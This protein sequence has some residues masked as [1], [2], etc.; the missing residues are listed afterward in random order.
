[1]CAI[2]GL[3]KKTIN[4]SDEKSM[5]KMGKLMNHRGPDGSGMYK[6]GELLML[7]KRLSIIDIQ[8]GKQ[9]IEDN[10]FVLVVNGEIYNDLEIRKE[11]KDYKFKTNSDSE[12]VLGLYKE[13]GIKGFKKL[14]G[15]YAFAIFDKKKK[16]LILGRDIFGIKPL[17]FFS[18]AD[19][20]IFSS[21]IQALIKSNYVSPDLNINKRNELLQIQ[22][23]SGR[24]TIFEKIKRVRPGEIILVKKNQIIESIIFKKIRKLKKKPVKNIH[25]KLIESVKLH[26]RSDVPYGSFFSGGIDSTLILYLMSIINSSPVKSYSI[27]FK[28]DL[29]EKDYL[30]KICYKLNSKLKFVEFTEKDFWSYLPKVA[31]IMDDPVIDYAI[32]PTYKL[33][34]IAKSDIKVVLT[35]EGGDEI[36]GGYGRYRSK[37]RRFLFKKEFL[38][39][40]AFSKFDYFKNILIGWDDSISFVKNKVYQTNFTDVQKAQYFDYEEWL[41]NDLLIKLDRC[42]MSQGIEGRTPLIDIEVFRNLFLIND[43]LK[44]SKGLGKYYIRQYFKKRL[45]YYFSFKKKSGFTVPINNWIPKYYKLLADILPKMKCLNNIFKKSKIESLCMNL[46][47]NKKAIV[48]VW[49]LIFFSLWFI[50]NIENKKIEGNTFDV[51]TD[52]I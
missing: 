49:R 33:A 26:Q 32:V 6:S 7:H 9:P 31:S 5:I 2:A 45:P 44:I 38:S 47:F 1:M 17:Y 48:P 28:E 16:E 29:A 8:G 36:F 22:F 34:E 50:S 41:P 46:Q 24:N 42:L 30:K 23:C 40:G 21:E 20:F 19:K 37:K 13:F 27:H 51:L 10:D 12:S 25:E 39:H 35:G 52:K 15:M 3:M 43:N 14:R 18:S 11:L 4:A